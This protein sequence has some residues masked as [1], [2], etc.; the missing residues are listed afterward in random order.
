MRL[1]FKEILGKL[2]TFLVNLINLEPIGSE[3]LQNVPEPL[4]KL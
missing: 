2:A 1:K 4:R 3:I